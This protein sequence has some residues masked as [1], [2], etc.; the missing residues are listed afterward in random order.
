MKFSPAPVRCTVPSPLGNLTLAAYDHALVG[1]WFELQQHLPDYTK[2]RV[3]RDHPVLRTTAEQLQQYFDGQRRTFDVPLNLG[4]GTAFQQRVWQ[5]LGAIA[6]GQSR[7]YGEV[8]RMV[9]SAPRAVGQAI[10]MEM[11]L[12]N[13]TLSAAEALQFGL[14]NRVVP[15]DAYLDEALK[16]AEQVASRAPAAIRL[17]KKMVNHTYERFLAE[18]LFEEKNEF[19]DLF[20]TE[21]QKEGMQA[22]AEKRK[23]QWR[24]K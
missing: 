23:P 16:L 24:G 10:A 8:A 2:W 9:R 13:R 15:L 4:N 17:G 20:S 5:A 14:V 7:T 22:F 11:V 12:N 18:A 6:P 19:Y 1:L 3:D 21:D